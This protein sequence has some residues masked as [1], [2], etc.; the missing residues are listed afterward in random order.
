[1]NKSFQ[2]FEHE[3]LYFQK[4]EKR[5]QLSKKQ[6]EQLEAFYGDGKDFPYYNLINKGVKFCEYVGVLQIG[7]TTIEVLPKADKTASKKEWQGKLIEMLKTVGAFN[8]H[9]PSSSN[10]T[11]KHN[12]ILDLYFE[13]F[14]VELEYLVRRGLIKKY[15]KKEGNQLALKGS[16]KFGKHIQKNLVHKE[17]FYTRHTTYDSIHKLHSILY[18]AL[19]LLQRINAN[20][21]LISRIE[22]LLLDFPI[23]P[24][25]KVT[26]ST[27]DKIVYNRKNEPYENALNIAQLILLNYHPD[28]KQG[29]DN[30][31]AL[32]FDMNLLWEQFVAYSLKKNKAFQVSLQRSKYFWKPQKGRSSSL[33][34]D[35]VVKFNKKNYVLDTKWKSLRGKNPSPDDL[36]QLFAYLHYFDAEKVGLIYPSN[37]SKTLLGN[38]YSFKDASEKDCSIIE[39]ST[40][41]NI[42]A[43]QKQILD[44]I[45]LWIIQNNSL[46]K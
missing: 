1:M 38:F 13:L 20:T 9:S 4:G 44:Q 21:S 35:I 41:K 17:R 28:I 39:I 8:I 46:S 31:L 45:E 22:N 34:P 23:L 7:A 11:L 40:E 14:I 24:N 33:Q 36:R 2:I 15:R 42:K 29:K 3:A 30:V 6:L 12:S 43:W 26:Q 18:K 25:I 16:I 37:N 32:M 19:N 5:Q 10:L 27:F